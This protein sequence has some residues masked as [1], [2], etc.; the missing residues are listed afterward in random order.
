M[1]Y[2]NG[3][4]EQKNFPL[5]LVFLALLIIVMIFNLPI[6]MVPAGHRGVVMNFGAV[7][8][9]IK[10]E[11]L[12]FKLPFIQTV[13]KMNVQVS[14]Q[15]VKIEAASKDLQSVT[16]EIALNFH[17][18]PDRVSDVYQKLGVNFGDN[19]IYPSLSES[20]KAVSAKYTAEELITKRAVVRDEIKTTMIAKMGN[21]GVLVD[22]INIV[23]FDFSKSF[24][25]AIENKVTA[26][27]NA[28]ASKNKLEQ[29]KYEAEQSIATAKG[30]AEAIR[31]QAEAINSQGGA[32]Y[33]NL[34]AVKQWNGVLPVQM[35]PNAAMPFINLNK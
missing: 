22:D 18:N 34:Q 16:S 10:G 24:N 4:G 9:E 26:E 13:K 23:N 25:E 17:L 19:I 33:V 15:Q 2:T 8:G 14:R 35:I 21:N 6:I 31:I 12:S 7:T 27:Q 29:V 11:G 30:Q 20:V 1:K 28:L 32:D 3:E 5:G